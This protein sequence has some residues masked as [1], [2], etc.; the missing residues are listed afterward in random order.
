[1]SLGNHYVYI[2]E[3]KDGTYYTGYTTDVEHRMK[4]H[5]SGTGAKYTRSRG[6]FQLL[7]EKHYS[8][9]MEA[10]KAEYQIKQLTRQ[11]K[12]VLIARQRGVETVYPK[13]L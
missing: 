6:P 13:E 10:M 7:Y 4:A 2:L 9:K 11:Q 12:R 8:T 5:E 1:M 3:C